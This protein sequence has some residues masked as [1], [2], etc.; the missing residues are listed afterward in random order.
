MTQTLL[1][2]IA[3]SLLPS[4]EEDYKDLVRSVENEEAKYHVK[5]FIL[6]CIFCILR[7]PLLV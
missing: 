6:V 1:K 4:R 7:T 5:C 2:G 3:L